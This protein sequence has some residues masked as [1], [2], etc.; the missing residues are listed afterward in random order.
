M[1]VTELAV[2]SS[3]M[4]SRAGDPGQS[5]VPG[6]VRDQRA[7]LSMRSLAILAISACIGVLA[8]VSAGVV[9]GIHT[10][11]VAGPGAGIALGLAGGLVAMAVV[12]STIAAT[13]HSLLGPPS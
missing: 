4:W 12:G 2:R 6:G 1:V 11:K 10:A 13:L 9:T 5:G 8:G 7:L 3:E